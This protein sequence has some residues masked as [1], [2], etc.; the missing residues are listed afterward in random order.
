MNRSKTT[1]WLMGLGSALLI[2]APAAAQK[3]EPPP[4]PA[5][6]PTAPATPATP[7]APAVAPAVESGEPAAAPPEPDPSQEANTGATE[8]GNVAKTEAAPPPPPVKEKRKPRV[9]PVFVRPAEE[10]EAPPATLDDLGN[11]QSH[12]QIF[13]HLRASWISD[14]K[15]DPF[16]QQDVLAGGG[17]GG[18]LVLYAD[19]QLSVAAVGL[20]EGVSSR[21]D[22]RGEAAE[23]GLVRG[24][25]GPELR[26]HWIP[27]SYVFLRALPALLRVDASLQESTSGSKLEDGYFSFA[28]DLGAGLAFAFA[29]AD[30]GQGHDPHFWV[31]A[32]GGYGIAVLDDF[33]FSPEEG[34][35]P[36]R[37]QPVHLDAPSLNAPLMRLSVAI[38][39]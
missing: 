12:W 7:A 20:F 2:A 18:G 11:F 25:L 14:P 5:A 28:A 3:K 32:E 9:R 35:G 10:P 29:G 27:R 4:A 16:N 8:P 1:S 6:A 26:Y 17:I 24:A 38:T 30:S 33:D 19:R 31:V 39:L 13:A 34:A 22:A 37:F 36:A 21:A 15:F 23:L